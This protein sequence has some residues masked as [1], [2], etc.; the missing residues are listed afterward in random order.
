MRWPRQSKAALTPRAARGDRAE[1]LA[2]GYLSAHGFE[3]IERNVRFPV[4][5]IDIV[6]R[7]GDA[8]CFVEVRSTTSQAWGGALASITSPKQRR[9]IRAAQWYL[10]S[11]R[12]QY[13]PTPKD[14][15]WGYIDI[16]FDVV[17]IA[18]LDGSAPTVEL[19]RGAFTAD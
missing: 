3:I 12:V 6:A 14:L 10:Q 4:G 11:C 13:T 2:C 16:R 9:L 5:E 19:I 1:R 8:L 18:W 15:V 17:A 7:E